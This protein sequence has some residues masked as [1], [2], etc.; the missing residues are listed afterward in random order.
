MWVVHQV[1]Q[2]TNIDIAN[3]TKISLASRADTFKN[4]QP[5]SF[6]SYCD[7]QHSICFPQITCYRTEDLHCWLFSRGLSTD[8]DDRRITAA[9]TESETYPQASTF[10]FKVSMKK[11]VD[12]NLNVFFVSIRDMYQSQWSFVISSPLRFVTFTVELAIRRLPA[13]RGTAALIEKVLADCFLD[14]PTACVECKKQKI[15]AENSCPHFDTYKSKLGLLKSTG[16]YILALLLHLQLHAPL[17]CFEK[18]L[19]LT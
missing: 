17:L 14:K 13:L 5:H 3:V 1:S 11:W 18:H 10:D 4:E 15:T 19:H 6:E 7:Y 9:E 12:R 16:K 2:R 8:T